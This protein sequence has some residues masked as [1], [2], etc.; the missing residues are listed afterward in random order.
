[1][2]VIL[3]A[4]LCLASIAFMIW[5]L[6]A[7]FR[8]GKTKSRCHIVHLESRP[9]SDANRQSKFKLIPGGRQQPFPRAG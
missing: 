2:A 4:A 5:F 7:L 8:D 3:T 1:M 6:V 9:S